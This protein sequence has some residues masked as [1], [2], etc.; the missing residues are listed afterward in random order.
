MVSSEIVQPRTGQLQM[1]LTM[2]TFTNLTEILCKCHSNEERLFYILYAHKEILNKHELQRSIANQSY[3]TL[4]SDKKNLSKGLLDTYP[5]AP[6]IFKDSV[7]VDLLG[8]RSIS[9]QGLTQK[10]LFS[11]VLRLF[12]LIYPKRTHISPHFSYFCGNNQWLS[13]D[14]VNFDDEEEDF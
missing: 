14:D 8:S 7:F 13:I 9:L 3:A 12:S 5:N 11:C 2:I 1:V 6:V 4:L 10:M